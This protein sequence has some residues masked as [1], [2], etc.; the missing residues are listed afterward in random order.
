MP[1][2]LALIVMTLSAWA[3]VMSFR[4]NREAKQTGRLRFLFWHIPGWGE[5]DRNPTFFKF[6][7]AQD[8]YR[9]FFFGL[10]T[11]VT[12]AFFLEAIGVIY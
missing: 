12:G 9:T 7:L 3:T 10:L 8:H 1:A 11:I 2:W 4:A 6:A 5:R